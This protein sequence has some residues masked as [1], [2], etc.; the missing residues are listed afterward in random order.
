MELF[1]KMI[2]KDKVW[3]WGK[4]QKKLFKE[5]KEKFIKELILKIYQLKLPIKIKINLSNFALR[6]CL[7]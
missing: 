2:R 1:I 4:K 6:V 5:I 7:I 3:K